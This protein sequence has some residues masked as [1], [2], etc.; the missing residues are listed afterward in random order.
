MGRPRWSSRLTVED[1]LAMT[2]ESFRRAGTWDCASGTTGTV[3]WASSVPPSK[4]D[5]VIRK[6]ADGIA[7]HIPRQYKLLKS[8]FRLIEESVIPVTTTRP[9]LGGTRRWFRCPIGSCGRRAGR[10]YLP[11]GA[12]VFGCRVCYNLTYQSAQTHDQRKYALLRDPAQ[13]IAALESEKWSRKFL[14]IGAHILAVRR[15][16]RGHAVVVS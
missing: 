14:G 10:L 2:V 6:S 13:L 7:I 9:H 5:Y 12:T 4:V 11:P 8:T 16:R 3:I 15:A 1:C